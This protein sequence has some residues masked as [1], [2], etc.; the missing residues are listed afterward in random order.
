MDRTTSGG[1]SNPAHSIQNLPWRA[2]QRPQ[3]GTLGQGEY[4]GNN[5]SLTGI[6]IYA[7]VDSWRSYRN[8]ATNLQTSTASILSAEAEPFEPSSK[9]RQYY[10]PYEPLR[11]VHN[12]ARYP[13]YRVDKPYRISNGAHERNTVEATHASKKKGKKSKKGAKEELIP[14]GSSANATE[15]VELSAAFASRYPVRSNRGLTDQAIPSIEEPIA[16]KPHVAG[17]TFRRPNNKR[18]SRTKSPQAPETTAEYRSQAQKEPT[19]LSE[20]R[21]LLVVLDLNGT[22]LYRNKAAC[23]K[24]V[25]VRPGVTPLLDYLFTNHVVMVYTSAM[26]PSAAQMVSQ[27][28]HPKHRQ[29]LAAVWA[30]DKLD[31]TEEQFANKVQ[32]YKQL[33]KIWNDETIQRTAGTGSS[34]DQSNTILVD[35]SKL[36]ALAQPH[37]LLQVPEYTANDDP[38]K[39]KL[40]LTRNQN[41]KTQQDI[42]KQLEM[43]LEELKYQ[44]DV[45]RLIRKWQTGELEVPRIPGQKIV[46][47]E[48]I[49]QKIVKEEK[50][51]TEANEKCQPLPHLLTPDSLGEVS[52]RDGDSVET[53]AQISEDD[54]EDRG[55][56]L[57]PT[58]STVSSIDEDVFGELLRG[59][60]K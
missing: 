34:W 31:L 4:Y 39:A 32:V 36:K 40:K 45:S 19:R 8:D 29:Q 59:T 20:P 14:S 25:H 12:Y 22:L 11:S 46:V 48:N 13:S 2:S 33:D 53:P 21:K 60:G 38:G 18:Q 10:T 49:D 47:E 23:N 3:K 41:H 5:I 1:R 55:A 57:S 15:P 7:L 54:D 17:L 56:P 26:P 43:K 16:S 51:T 27:F 6:D 37:N 52:T 35:D 58:R 28:L 9:V 42:L 44:E 24:K 30:R 50:E